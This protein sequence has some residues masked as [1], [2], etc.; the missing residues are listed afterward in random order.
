MAINWTYDPVLVKDVEDKWK[1]FRNRYEVACEGFTTDIDGL[2]FELE[3]SQKAAL[4][5][6]VIALWTDF[7]AAVDTLKAH[8]VG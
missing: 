7:K 6:D 2:S 5:A 3:E 8:A 4:R 1:A